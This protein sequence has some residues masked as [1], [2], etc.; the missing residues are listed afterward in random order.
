MKRH[1][2]SVGAAVF[3]LCASAHAQE[4]TSTPESSNTAADAEAPPNKEQVCTDSYQKAQLTRREGKSALLDARAAARVCV[5]AGC[6]SWVVAD[7][8]QWLEQ[9]DKRIP[10]IVFSAKNTAD[11]DLAEVSVTTVDGAPIVS[12]LDGHSIEFE[13]GPHTF[14]FT[15]KDGARREK[16]VIVIEGATAQA[17]QVV[18][19]ASPEELAELRRKQQSD[20]RLI[21]IESEKK[22]DQSLRYA[23]YGLVGLGVIGL[24]I[25]AGFGISALVQKNDLNCPNNNCPS[26][27][28]DDVKAGGRAADVSTIGFIAGGVLAAGGVALLLI[29]KLQAKAQPSVGPNH[30]GLQFGGRF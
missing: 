9:L 15:T 11:R 28:V 10:K 2:V 13:P 18:F 3:A 17:V 22:P 12:Q 1:F 7:C 23:G 6:A 8:S 24:G 30:A 19:D 16:Q 4:P 5:S 20:L 26:G 25:G 21:P 27:L 14:V 29:P